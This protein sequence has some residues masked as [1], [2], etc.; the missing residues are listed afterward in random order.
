M[1]AHSLLMDCHQQRGI[2]KRDKNRTRYTDYCLLLNALSYC[3]RNFT[4]TNGV[5]VSARPSVLSRAARSHPPHTSN[6]FEIFIIVDVN[7]L[8]SLYPIC[9]LCVCMCTVVLCTGS[10][11]NDENWMDDRGYPL[12]VYDPL[13]YFETGKK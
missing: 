5:T 2:E 8:S 9:V 13:A 11:L 6:G 1:C 7:L 4:L 3:T 12:R 10:Y